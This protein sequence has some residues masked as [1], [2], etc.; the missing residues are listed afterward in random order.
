MS[1]VK[2]EI[3]RPHSGAF[4]NHDIIRGTITLVV[5][6][7]ISLNWIQVKLE[8]EST[9]Q[10]SIPK[11]NG[12]K[13]KE[14]VIQD[15]HKILYDS[16]IVFPPDNIRQV[17]QAKEFTLAPGNYSYPFA[18]KIPLNNSCVKR[19]GITNK[20]QINKKTLDVMI[21][22]GNF[23]S[24]FVRHKAQ[25][26]YQEFVSG[27]DGV[28]QKNPSQPQLPYHI[29]SQLPPSISG[30][31]NFATIKYYVKVTCKRSSFFKVNLR[32]F[33]PFTFLPIETDPQMDLKEEHYKEVFVRKEVIFRNRIPTIIGVEVKKGAKPQVQRV[34]SQLAQQI[35]PKKQGFFQRLF[36][37]D[38]LRMRATGTTIDA[39]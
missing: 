33:E 10:L 14:K 34:P 16:S 5:T 2:I 24:D 18:F 7:A 25:Q 15:V 20:V 4:T 32:S 36:T 9:T 13:E 27:P 17:S 21:N 19:G 8:G 22:N 11:V 26:Y 30:M 31:G 39:A 35:Q 1:D 3:E 23:N 12:K 37:P 29:T 28:T 6:R 38:S